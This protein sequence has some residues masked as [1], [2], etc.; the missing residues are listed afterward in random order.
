MSRLKNLTRQLR[1]VTARL[2]SENGRLRNLL[3][4]D[5]FRQVAESERLRVYR[6][7]TT[8]SIILIEGVSTEWDLSNQIV[9]DRALDTQLEPIDTA[10]FLQDG[11]VG[12]LL[13]GISAADARDWAENLCAFCAQQHDRQ[14]NYKVLVYPAEVPELLSGPS[15]RG[16]RN[17]TL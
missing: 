15:R 11:R 12:I 3:D 16:S 5:T 8:L 9:F 14:L 17:L 7:G 4:S 6:C 2:G 1:R 13:P 10:G